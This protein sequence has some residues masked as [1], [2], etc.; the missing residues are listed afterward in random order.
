MLPSNDGTIRIWFAPKTATI[1]I[2]HLLDEPRWAWTFM[3]APICVSEYRSL[4]SSFNNVTLWG[5]YSINIATD[6]CFSPISDLTVHVFEHTLMTLFWCY[7]IHRAFSLIRSSLIKWC[8]SLK[9]YRMTRIVT[10]SS[11]SLKEVLSNE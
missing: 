11:T 6:W 5:E 1:I 9:F 3:L 8:C 7:H 2:I 4:R 10:K